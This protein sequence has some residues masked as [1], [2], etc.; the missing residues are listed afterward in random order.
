MCQVGD[1]VQITD[2]LAPSPSAASQRP[3]SDPDCGLSG[4]QRA[5]AMGLAAST[6]PLAGRGCQDGAVSAHLDD[7]PCFM[8]NSNAT[9]PPFAA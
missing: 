6:V 3:G 7:H 1:I 8:R 5:E 4:E 9:R 2:E